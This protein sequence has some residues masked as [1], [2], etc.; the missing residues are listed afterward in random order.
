M[1]RNENLKEGEEEMMNVEKL[2]TS[3]MPVNGPVMGNNGAAVMGPGPEVEF[4]E[5]KSDESFSTVRL[6]NGV[7]LETDHLDTFMV[8]DTGSGYCFEA[9]EDGA[10][11]F[12][13]AGEKTAELRL[14]ESYEAN[15]MVISLKNASGEEKVYNISFLELKRHADS[16]EEYILVRVGAD[17]N[18]DVLSKS[19]SY[20]LR[21]LS[22][23]MRRIVEHY[24]GVISPA[25]GQV[26]VNCCI[27]LAGAV[28]ALTG[29]GLAAKPGKRAIFDADVH[30][31]LPFFTLSQISGGSIG[32]GN[33]T[34]R[35]H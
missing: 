3:N 12:G 28:L 19:D 5:T 2:K 18:P 31:M 9:R 23:S 6:S 25:P 33:P 32:E 22:Y 29:L 27:A 13:K 16:G 7:K 17:D 34:E 14:L 8:E 35:S 24:P 11:D 26:V 10:Y 15:Q 1:G 30:L 4:I 20:Y 21:K